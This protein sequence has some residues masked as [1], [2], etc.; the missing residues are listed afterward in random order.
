MLGK[1]NPLQAYRVLRPSG[2]LLTL[3]RVGLESADTQ[4]VHGLL[5]RQGDRK[6]IVRL[7]DSKVQRIPDRYSKLCRWSTTGKKIVHSGLKPAGFVLVKGC[8]KD[9]GIAND[10]AN[11]RRDRHIG[12]V[13]CID[14]R[15][16]EVVPDGMRRFKVGRPSDVWSLGCILYQMVYAQPPFANLS[17]YRKMRAIP[18]PTYEILFPRE[19]RSKRTPTTWTRCRSGTRSA[20]GV[21]AGRR[22][23]PCRAASHATS[24]SAP[25]SPSC[26]RRARSTS[27]RGR[28][29]HRACVAAPDRVADGVC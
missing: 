13:N 26:S 7:L 24:R 4:T 6:R 21:C 16:L 2:D 20:R 3:K 15:A 8:F 23:T 1:R 25:R 18:D 9:V 22:S 12:T 5:R 28:A 10:T 14:P 29:A 27:S 17:G 11:T 19:R